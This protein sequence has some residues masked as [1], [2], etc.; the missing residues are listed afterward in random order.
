MTNNLE[1]KSGAQIADPMGV[2]DDRRYAEIAVRNAQ[3]YQTAA[4]FGQCALDNFL[5]ED[6]AYALAAAF[7]QPEDISWV[8]RTNKNN[9]RRFQNDETKLPPL[10]RAM[11]REFNSRQFTLFLETLTG[12]ESLI[13]DPYFVGG[14]VHISSAGDFLNVHADFNWHHKLQAYRRVNALLYL[15][16]RWEPEWDGALEFWDKTLTKPVASHLPLF[17]RLVI[18]STGEHSNHGQRLPNRCPPGVQ[19]KVLNLYFYTSHR[20]DGD[21]AAPHFTVYK[22]ASAPGETYDGQVTPQISHALDAS[23]VAVE[24]GAEYR[25]SGG[26]EG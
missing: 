5:P 13:P 23:P 24:L 15:P 1:A 7:P 4:P 2:F 16:E 18:F 8:E 26:A 20:E 6:L 21:V 19:R 25:K 14:G 22:T 9:R 3:A 17:N 10:L 11:L 12:I